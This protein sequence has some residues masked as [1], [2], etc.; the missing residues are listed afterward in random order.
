MTLASALKRA[1][2]VIEGAF[3]VTFL[4]LS[5]GGG[6]LLAYW[7]FYDTAVPLRVLRGANG[8][9]LDRAL[10]PQVER[11]GQLKVLRHY[12]IDRVRIGQVNRTIIDTVVYAYPRADA[13]TEVGCYQG[14]VHTVDIPSLLPDGKYSYK[15]TATYAINP[16]H[17]AIVELPEIVFEVVSDPKGTPTVKRR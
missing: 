7:T 12:C 4:V 9:V 5:V 3:V 15:V 2:I 13:L 6:A 1:W 11:G 14:Q 17:T 8:E 16:V 10:T